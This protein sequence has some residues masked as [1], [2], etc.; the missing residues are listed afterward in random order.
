MVGAVYVAGKYVLQR[1]EEIKETVLTERSAKEK[2]VSSSF[3]V[4]SFAGTRIT[5]LSFW[6]WCIIHMKTTHPYDIQKTALVYF[7]YPPTDKSSDYKQPTKTLSA[8]HARLHV[9]HHGIHAHTRD[10]NS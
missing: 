8:Q 2:W 7:M 9:H 3:L 1:L 5:L 4:Q 10:Q 6:R